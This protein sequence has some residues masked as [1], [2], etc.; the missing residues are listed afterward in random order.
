[1]KATMKMLGLLDENLRLP[2]VPVSEGTR[3]RLRGVLAD[4]GLSAKGT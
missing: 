2:M 3:E 1:V 4:A